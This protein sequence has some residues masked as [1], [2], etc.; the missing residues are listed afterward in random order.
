[1]NGMRKRDEH[2][3]DNRSQPA[4][5]ETG[6]P[7]GSQ[8]PSLNA[9]SKRI[10]ELTE[11]TEEREALL[12]RLAEQI[13]SGTYQVDEDALASVLLHHLRSGDPGDQK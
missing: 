4:G 7:A 13:R 5:S 10:A 8:G 9:L 3:A 1:M 2:E 12:R 11:G 6:A